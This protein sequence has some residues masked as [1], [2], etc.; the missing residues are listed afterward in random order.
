M[1]IQAYAS[2]NNLSHVRGYTEKSV[3][4]FWLLVNLFVHFL[5]FVITIFTSYIYLALLAYILQNFNVR[6]EAFSATYGGRSIMDIHHK[7]NY[8]IIPQNKLGQD[9]FIRAT[10]LRG[11]TNI[12]RMPSGD[13]KPIK[14]PVSKN[15]LDSHLKGKLC[16]KVKMMVTVIIADAE[17]FLY[18]Q[19]AR[20][21]IIQEMNMWVWIF[22]YT[23]RFRFTNF[24]CL[25]DQ[26]VMQFLR[27]GGLTSPQYTVAI[28]LTHDQSFGSESL[29]YQQ[30]ARTCGSSS[31]SFSSEVELVTWNEVFFFKVDSPV[32]KFFSWKYL[33]LSFLCLQLTILWLIYP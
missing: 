14:V 2:W 33:L 8:Y 3:N 5:H 7:G 32:C 20:M 6:Q 22:H 10:E 18:L 9:I 1:I 11:L 26:H 17:V 29:H 27:V 23:L 28:R 4:F 16:T 19:L 30:S 13:M 21:L 12:I 25:L 31:D 15:M 24:T